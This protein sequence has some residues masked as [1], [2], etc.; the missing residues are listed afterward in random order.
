MDDL[1]MAEFDVK[2]L[3]SWRSTISQ[4]LVSLKAQSEKLQAKI[5]QRTAN[6]Q[7]IDQLLGAT[8]G[9]VAAPPVVSASG[10]GPAIGH[11]R[12]G[13][14]FTPVHLYWPA[15]LSALVELGG[16]ASGD[17]VIDRVGEKLEGV[18][19]PADREMLPSGVDLRWR[20]RVAWQR[21]N[22][23]RQGLIR[24]DSPRGVWEITDKGRQWLPRSE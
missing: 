7:A 19:T 11:T 2:V 12:R 21:F 1:V 16:R 3:K 13:H 15:I 20:N 14:A 8:D 24:N 6:L 10:N 4:E 18:L 17:S 5:E 9:A 23:V 22:M